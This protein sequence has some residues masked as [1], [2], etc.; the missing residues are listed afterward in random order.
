MPQ[1][2]SNKNA[3]NNP[4]QLFVGIGQVDYTPEPGLPLMGNFRDDYAATGVH[5][6]LYCKA[7]VFA[8]SAGTKAALASVD[9]CMLDRS[10]VGMMR[11]YISSNCDIP[12]ENILISATH[13]HSGPATM[14]LYTWPKPTDEKIKEFLQRAAQAVI[15]ADK[16]LRPS[17]ISVG[18]AIEDRLSFCRRLK[19]KDGKTH[20]NW[21]S[22]EPDFVFNTLGK[23][24]PQILSFFTGENDK[25][26]SAITNFALHPA[27]LDYAN[28]L[29]TADYPGFL[30]EGMKKIFGD[31]F[32]TLFF[33]GCAGNINHIDYADKTAPR[34]GYVMAQRVGYMLA[35]GVACARKHAVPISTGPIE[36]ARQSVRV[37]R[38]KI[39]KETYQWSRNVVKKMQEGRLRLGGSDGLPK[40]CNAPIWVWMYENQDRDDQ[41]EVMVIRVGNAGFVG[42]P[43]EPF[44]ELGMKIKNQSPADNTMVIELA[45][46]AVGY[47]PT[48]Q[49]FDQ[50]GYET[51]TGST[52]YVK[53]TGEKL[54]EAAISQLKKLFNKTP[55]K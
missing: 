11:E 40:E 2:N 16:N 39:S 1:S 3:H 48:E 14:S 54:A 31:N 27:I 26:N 17:N 33:N 50:G 30:A 43:G 38:L 18:Y 6:P 46:D 25:H 42:L 49:A 21:E 36:V 41:L 7:V 19:C 22:I 52:L 35:A 55:A 8:D 51:L 13:T 5:D 44:C 10:Q 45:N 53:G 37:E 15:V 4:G 23:A 20:M 12:A 47:I 28:S 9:V 29:Y 24:D 32:T 34:R